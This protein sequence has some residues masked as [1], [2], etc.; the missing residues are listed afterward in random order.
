MAARRSRP[1]LEN[2]TPSCSRA[3][4]LRRAAQLPQGALEWAAGAQRLI[5]WSIRER[6]V[7]DRPL[8]TSSRATRLT[9]IDADIHQEPCA[10]LIQVNAGP[11]RHVHALIAGR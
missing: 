8:P 4:L 11:K 7:A 3:I 6:R 1:P 9:C 5:L 10:S 2:V